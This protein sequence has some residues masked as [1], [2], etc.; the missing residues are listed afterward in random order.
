MALN[1]EL[2]LPKLQENFFPDDSFVSKSLDDSAFIEAHRVHIPNS[3]TPSKV[4]KD[5]SVFPASIGTRE[6]HEVT[7]DLHIFSVDPARVHKMSDVELSYDK[8][9]SM[10]N[11]NR[12]E[13]QRVAHNDI[14]ES[15]AKAYSSVVR[16][17]GS[18]EPAHTYNGATG[19][20]KQVTASDVLK[21]KT[22]FD[23]QLLPAEGRYL[24]L[25][26]DMY[27]AFLES[28]T[29][30]NKLAFQASADAQRGILG[31]LYGFGVMSRAQVLRVKSDAETILFGKE[32]H[33]PTELAAGL[34]W[35]E[36]CVSRAK[37]GMN[38]YLEESKAEWY[39]DVFSLDMRAGGGHR[40]FDKAGIALLVQ[41]AE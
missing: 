26:V 32:A 9:M 3:G 12:S 19:K 28:L 11:N 23:K 6:D 1:V 30:G 2:W 38:L 35:Q 21:L 7:Y 22:I 17:S 13:L 40:R 14:L 31:R 10:I 29:E 16:T 15:W 5:R 27:N 20:R 39:G 36:S 33:E 37:G 24:L 25:D 8:R 4:E 34:A 41:G 18:L